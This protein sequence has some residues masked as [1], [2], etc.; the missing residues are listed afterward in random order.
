MLFQFHANIALSDEA[1]HKNEDL[2]VEV[3]SH[4]GRGFDLTPALLERTD[5][6]QSIQDSWFLVHCN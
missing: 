2:V 4:N 6:F 3:F 5:F 1:S